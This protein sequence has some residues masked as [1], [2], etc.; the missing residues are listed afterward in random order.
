VLDEETP[1]VEAESKLML[2]KRDELEVLMDK[3]NLPHK[4]ADNKAK[5]VTAILQSGAEGTKAGDDALADA[6]ADDDE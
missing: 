5:L 1:P 2:K 4:K 3:H 6:V